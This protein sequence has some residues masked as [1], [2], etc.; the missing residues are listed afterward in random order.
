M[1]VVCVTKCMPKTCDQ[2][3]GAFYLGSMPLWHWGVAS[4]NSSRGIV[5]CMY[6][7]YNKGHSLDL[8]RKVVLHDESFCSTQIIWVINLDFVG[9]IWAVNKMDMMIIYRLESRSLC[10][11]WWCGVVVVKKTVIGIWKWTNV[12]V[13]V[14]E[15]VCVHVD[16]RIS[17]KA[18]HIHQQLVQNPYISITFW[19]Y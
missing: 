17:C 1:F 7:K 9:C 12:C 4:F 15:C 8:F 11:G 18:M 19:N 14:G 5:C 10:R 3:N 16:I 6:R 13:F 2:L